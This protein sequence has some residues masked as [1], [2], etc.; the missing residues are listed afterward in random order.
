MLTSTKQ[1]LDFL[2][3]SPMETRLMKLVIKNESE[4]AVVA[5]LRDGLDTGPECDPQD[6]PSLVNEVL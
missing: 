6:L 5:H 4:K 2:E 1:Y 3:L